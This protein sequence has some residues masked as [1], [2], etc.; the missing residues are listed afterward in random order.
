MIPKMKRQLAIGKVSCP[1]LINMTIPNF[2]KWVI[3]RII[4]RL[5]PEWQVHVRSTTWSNTASFWTILDY[6]Y[7][8]DHCIWQ[9]HLASRELASTV[10]QTNSKAHVKALVKWYY[11]KVQALNN[12]CGYRSLNFTA[13]HLGIAAVRYK[14][15]FPEA[16]VDWSKI[17]TF[18]QLLNIIQDSGA[19]FVP[20]RLPLFE[21]Y[22]KQ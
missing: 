5:C 17:K 18:N 1:L 2:E 20:L 4:T 6:C 14:T 12:K 7:Y 10:M 3:N 22:L 13:F 16:N 8:G 21:Q 19:D 11:V 15:L 9:K